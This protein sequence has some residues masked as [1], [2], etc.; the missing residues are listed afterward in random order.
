MPSSVKVMGEEGAGRGALN[1]P[2][3]ICGRFQDFSFLGW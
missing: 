3:A 2:V 1:E